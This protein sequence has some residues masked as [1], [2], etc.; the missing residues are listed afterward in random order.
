MAKS[1]VG[2]KA[3]KNDITSGVSESPALTTPAISAVVTDSVRSGAT[4][5]ET[6]RLEVVKSES[7]ATV[8]PINLEQEIRRRAYELYEKRGYSGGS[9]TEDWLVAEREV[10]HRYTQQSA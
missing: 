1:K 8:L 4:K 2:S 3:K 5:A 6:K 9:E 7:R 10:L